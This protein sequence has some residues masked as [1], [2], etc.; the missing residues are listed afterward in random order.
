M[1]ISARAGAW[2]FSHTRGRRRASL[3][4]LTG[5]VARRCCL[6]LLPVSASSSREVERLEYEGY[7]PMAE[8]EMM[9]LCREAEAS[10]ARVPRR[11]GVRLVS[12]SSSSSSFDP[13]RLHLNRCEGQ[14]RIG[15]AARPSAGDASSIE[16]E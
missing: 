10:R 12:S 2:P 16:G 4:R 8:K 1:E 14:R 7:T 11:F 6:A 13:R 15:T 9:R 3:R 5:D